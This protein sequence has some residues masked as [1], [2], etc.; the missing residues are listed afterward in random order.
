MVALLPPHKSM[1]LS[2]RFWLLAVLLTT[3]LLLLSGCEG[4]P[5]Q[6]QAEAYLERA[7]VA[8]R[9]EKPEEALAAIE[10]ALAL[11]ANL[12]RAYYARAMVHRQQGDLSAT[13]ADLEQARTL[14]PKYLDTYIGLGR[15]YQ[16]M[17]DLAKT[18]A[19]YQ[20]A[21]EL[22]PDNADW[23]NNLCWA[24]GVF[25]EP[26]EGLEYCERAIELRAEPYIHDSRGLVYALLGDYGNAIIDFT[27]FVNF[28]EKSYPNQT[29][30]E[31]EQRKGWIKAMRAGDNPFTQ[32]VLDA[33]R[34]E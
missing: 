24:Y 15:T 29:F 34:T 25:N 21:L 11:D 33:L 28:Y 13:L 8:L 14:D 10:K 3:W 6:T 22:D 2:H 30:P 27:I 19:S 18:V 4:P 16:E 31:V 26:E 9:E 7:F 32:E 5:L 17:G 23:Y 20:K 12:P 1:P